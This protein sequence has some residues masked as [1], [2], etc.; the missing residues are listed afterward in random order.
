[1]KKIS[2]DYIFFLILMAVIPTILVMITSFIFLFLPGNKNEIVQSLIVLPFS[3]IIIPTFL[4]IK[5]E[6]V[7]LEELGIRKPSQVDIIIICVCI[8]ALYLF[9]FNNYKFDVILYLSFQTLIVAVSEEFWA[10]G[11]IFYILRKSIR[12]WLIVVVVSSLIFVFITHMNRGIIENLLFRMPGAL[13]MGYIYQK[14]GKLQYSILFHFIY[15][16]LGSL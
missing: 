1:M 13:I 15:N 16:V 14:T 6:K 3:F 7:L 10:R 5:K 12:S 4:L 8:I 9:L 11:I 2:I